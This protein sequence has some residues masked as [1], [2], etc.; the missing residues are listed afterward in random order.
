MKRALFLI[1]FCAGQAQA[2]DSEALQGYA[3]GDAAW[4]ARYR[5]GVLFAGITA[6]GIGSWNWGSA[7]FHFNDEHWFGMA[8]GSAGADKLGHAY[9]SYAMSD[10]I[11]SALSDRAD[12]RPQA[13][14]Y[15]WAFAAG[16]MLYVELFDGVS[17]DHG[18]SYEDMIA[19]ATG[20]AIAYLRNTHPRLAQTVDF[21]LQYWPSKYVSG[22]HPFTDYNGQTYIVA[23]KL[24]GFEATRRHWLRF[25]EWHLG[26]RSRGFVKADAASTDD[27]RTRLYIGASLNFSEI[28][29]GRQRRDRASRWSRAARTTLEYVQPP[30]TSLAIVRAERRRPA[31]SSEP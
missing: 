10:F 9:T 13:G 6:L 4:D 2:T 17:E 29:F 11:F 27:R 24:S 18:F 5:I 30:A 28:L 31:P 22:W 26:Y 19:N 15:A 12:S 3:L 25:V 23:I 20:Q 21:R 7:E 1:L 14:A 16:L 8:T